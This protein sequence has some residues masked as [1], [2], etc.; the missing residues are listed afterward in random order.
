MCYNLVTHLFINRGRKT[1]I[2]YPVKVFET[3]IYLRFLSWFIGVAFL[4]LAALFSLIYFFDPILF[5]SVSSQSRD[6]VLFVIFVSLAIVLLLSLLATRL[7][8]RSITKPIKI[9]VLELSKVVDNLFKT[10]QNLSEITQNNS[11]LSHALL[12]SS[13][14]Q[15]AGLKTGNKA[16][17]DMAKSLDEVAQ[18]TKSASVKARNVDKLAGESDA[19][20]KEALDSLVVVKQLLT[21][22]Q[23]LSQA[24]NRYASD[25]KDVSGRV[26]ALAET[27]KFLSLNVSI[28]ASK[29]SFS[30]DFSE[31]V[32]QIRELNI[33]S[34][35][36]ASAIGSL[37]SKM[38]KQIEQSKDSSDYQWKETNKTISVVSQTIMFL[39]KI[40]ENMTQISQ[41]VQVIDQEAQGTKAD[42]KDI[43]DMIK[44]LSVEAKALVGNVD[45]VTHTI[46]RQ[47]SITKS[48]NV[49]SSALNA[50]T[51]TLNDLVGE[52]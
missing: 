47:V 14:T 37:A 20:S 30:E 31:L 17:S 50:V 23:K 36:A 5:K 26:V 41:N 4:P 38:Q 2:N 16:V 44:K 18:K 33:V 11:G 15:Q 22:N 49:S 45:V 1:K 24:L 25:V 27:V 40:A 10:I 46:N 42:A 43:S 8:S 51:K 39:G 6:T 29:N 32:S 13:Q 3:K 9:S 19:K 35:Q 12:T 7:L 34:E 52:K 28:E 48:L 21:E